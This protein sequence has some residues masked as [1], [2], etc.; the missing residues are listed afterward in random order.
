MLIEFID[1]MDPSTDPQPLLDGSALISFSGGS[2]AFERPETTP[3]GPVASVFH[4]LGA[5][6]DGENEEQ[7]TPSCT[8]GLRLT[9]KDI[10]VPSYWAGLPLCPPWNH[11]GKPQQLQ[12]AWSKK[13]GS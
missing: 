6:G 1:Q 5:T 11:L 9:M 4:F 13:L 2:A 3:R 12:K 10:P 8:C 7:W